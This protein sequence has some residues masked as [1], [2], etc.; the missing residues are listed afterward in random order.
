MTTD[1][2]ATVGRPPGARRHMP[3][4]GAYA[5]I[6]GGAWSGGGRCARPR[7]PSVTPLGWVVPGGE[8]LACETARGCSRAVATNLQVCRSRGRNKFGFVEVLC[9]DLRR[10]ALGSEHDPTDLVSVVKEVCG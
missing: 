7:L 6:V 3:L 8:Q 5:G 2:G 1:V 4:D 9:R 10:K